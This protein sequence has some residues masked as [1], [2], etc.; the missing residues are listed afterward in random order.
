[1][2]TLRRRLF[3]WRRWH[4]LD[5]GCL[6]YLIYIANM[7]DIDPY[8]LLNSLIE[9]EEKRS[10]T[11]GPLKIMLRER[12][13]NH[14]IFLLTSESKIV[15]QMRFERTIWENP[16]QARDL[17]SLLIEDYR[18]RESSKP[19]S[20]IKD[21]RKG[22][23]NVDLRVTVTGKSEI[24]ERDSPHEHSSLRL[25]IASVADSSGSIRLP[26][27]NDQINAVSIGDQI[28]IKNASVKTFQGLLQIVPNRREG[29]LIIISKRNSY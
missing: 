2:R 4:S 28:D 12:S 6:E 1:L 8:E 14:A 16:T 23:K 26:L 10:T 17:C 11:C 7:H 20:S 13:K 19:P 5:V 18:P 3:Y 22:M 29:E 25:C 21:L 15:A 9:S 27:W 24:I